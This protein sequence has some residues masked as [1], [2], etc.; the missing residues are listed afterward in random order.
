MAHNLNYNSETGKYSFYSVKEKAWH[1]L[2]HIAEQYE[3]SE[4]VLTNSGLNFS[5]EKAPNIH[6]LPNGT[7][8]VSE[9]S[10][11]TYRTDTNEILGDQLGTDYHVV[12]NLEA[13]SFFDAIAG[14]DGI[15]YETAGALGKGERIF[16]TAK[17]PGY[18]KIGSDDVIEKY[19]FLTTSH[20]GKSCIIAA[21]TPVR[22]VCNN[23][24]TSALGNCSNII[25][26]R[27]TPNAS[28]QLKEAHKIM[29]MINTLSPVLEEVFNMWSKISISDD[30]MKKLIQLALAPNKETLENIKLGKED[31]NS[32]AFKNIV[33]DVFAYAMISDTQQ[34]ETT[35]GTLFGAYNAIT[36]YFQNV[37]EYKDNDAKIKSILYSGTA[38]TRT[39]TAF[40]LCEQFAKFGSA[41]LS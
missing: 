3:T 13:F 27:H 5:V 16:I 7:E 39:Q 15:Y 18:I 9:T 37:R 29:G 6:R 20:D 4:Q 14:K 31:E 25:N 26:I 28:I 24:L 17:L 8:I 19:L 2:G 33:E 21:F 32:T 30:E 36:G 34:M 22:I 38:Q 35:K 1:D 11:F 40:K 12:Q 23:T 41:A 10:F